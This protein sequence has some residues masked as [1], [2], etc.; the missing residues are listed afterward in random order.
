MKKRTKFG[1]VTVSGVSFG[2]HDL[3]W[4]FTIFLRSLMPRVGSEQYLAGNIDGGQ[5]I[6]E[7]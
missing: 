6:T 1:I 4:P 2:L 7:V 3:H 5:K